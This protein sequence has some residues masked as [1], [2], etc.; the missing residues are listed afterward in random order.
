MTRQTPS[1]KQLWENFRPTLIFVSQKLETTISDLSI[2][3]Y[4]RPSTRVESTEPRWC[5]KG[6]RLLVVHD[7]IFGPIQKIVGIVRIHS[8]HPP[9]NGAANASIAQTRTRRRKQRR[10]RTFFAGM[11]PSPVLQVSVVSVPPP[12]CRPSPSPVVGNNI[13]DFVPPHVIYAGE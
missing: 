1:T 12:R 9:S 5:S 11:M 2:R 3:L 7:Q 10:Y 4:A 6:H 8:R 13:S